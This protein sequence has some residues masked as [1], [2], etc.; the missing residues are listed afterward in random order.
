MLSE[1]RIGELLLVG[2][3]RSARQPYG[4]GDVLGLHDLDQAVIQYFEAGEYMGNG[5]E[6]VET[7]MHGD[8]KDG[9]G[10]VG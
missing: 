3:S 5:I 8:L 6:R 7:S 10:R 1:Q 9:S 4:I 2:R